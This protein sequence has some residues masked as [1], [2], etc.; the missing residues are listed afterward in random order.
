MQTLKEIREGKGWTA[1]RLAKES[2]LNPHTIHNIERGKHQP[3]VPTALSISFALSTCADQIM[4]FKP[5]IERLG[6]PGD[7][8]DCRPDCLGYK[9][10]A[11]NPNSRLQFDI[12]LSCDGCGE[13][14]TLD[15]TYTHP[16]SR[17]CHLCSA[18]RKGIR[19]LSRMDNQ[20][21]QALTMALEKQH[22]PP[23]EIYRD[24]GLTAE[25]VCR[26]IRGEKR[27]TRSRVEALVARLDAPELFE[28]LLAAGIEFHKPKGPEFKYREFTITCVSC[29]VEWK[30]PGR[31]VE[32]AEKYPNKWKSLRSV[33]RDALTGQALCQRC[34][35]DDPKRKAAAIKGLMTKGVYVDENDQLVPAQWKGK[36]KKRARRKGTN[37]RRVTG[38]SV[39]QVLG[40]HYIGTLSEE[41]KATARRKARDAKQG[42]RHRD[43]ALNQMSM[44][45]LSPELNNVT[46]CECWGCGRWDLVPGVKAG[47]QPH[48]HIQCTPE[49]I[50]FKR[51]PTRAHAPD[52]LN[53]SYAMAVRYYQGETLASLALEF[54]Y[55]TRDDNEELLNTNNASVLNRINMFIRGL[56]A[57]VKA[58]RATNDSRKRLRR[59]YRV[60]TNAKENPEQRMRIQK[61][62][63][64]K[65]RQRASLQTKLATLTV[66]Q[67]LIYHLTYKPT[68]MGN[69]K[70]L[71][72]SERGGYLSRV[73]QP[74]AINQLVTQ[75]GIP[76]ANLNA[77]LYRA[78]R[79][80]IFVK[81]VS[82]ADPVWAI[83]PEANWENDALWENFIATVT[84]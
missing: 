45:K 69:P 8:C 34:S 10:P 62:K 1:N 7:L 56:P 14:R 3:T 21:A 17:Y 27:P 11:S 39:L 75:T 72:S 16:H 48:F 59:I 58:P 80:P 40:R 82:K 31:L 22:Q 19:H 52:Y 60:L 36:Q 77:Y 41:Q 38:R 46:F 76:K 42:T 4:E 54:D 5:Q 9:I 84:L 33:D 70:Y 15:T 23:S 67:I 65:E 26:W 47:E 18:R 44:A 53:G 73:S 29:Q 71:N 24:A 83:N 6:Q 37:Q 12:R 25:T 78:R 32:Q 50:A 43:A 49:D 66:P 13:I 74:K 61:A 63:Q 35:Y 2:G 64:K 81:L 55:C 20:F 30:A 79:D 28:A 51:R 57:D 68:S